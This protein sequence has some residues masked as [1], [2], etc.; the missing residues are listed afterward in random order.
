MSDKKL[1]TV[2][3]PTRNRMK[4]HFLDDKT[5]SKQEMRNLK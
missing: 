3:T 1:K 5:Q 4:T 2:K